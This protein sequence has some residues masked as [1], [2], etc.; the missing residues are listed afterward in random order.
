MSDTSLPTCGSSDA[1]TTDS[2]SSSSPVSSCSS[3]T[4]FNP[5]SIEEIVNWTLGTQLVNGFY[6]DDT[7]NPK[8]DGGQPIY[9]DYVFPV[10]LSYYPSNLGTEFENQTPFYYAEASA[11]GKNEYN[12]A[13]FNGGFYDTK[14]PLWVIKSSASAE[15][16]WSTKDT[17]KIKT[18]K[19]SYNV[20]TS[21]QSFPST[22]VDG[23]YQIIGSPIEDNAIG[24][25]VPTEDYADFWDSGDGENTAPSSSAPDVVSATVGQ[26]APNSVDFTIPASDSYTITNSS[27]V[28]RAFS[29]AF[30]LQYSL[31][32]QINSGLGTALENSVTEEVKAG[33]DLDFS[34]SSE[35]Y[36]KQEESIQ[37]ST[38]SSVTNNYSETIFYEWVATNTTYYA[39]FSLPGYLTAYQSNLDELATEDG[40]SESP[41]SDQVYG[42]YENKNGEKVK[43]YFNDSVY[44]LLSNTASSD[45]GFSGTYKSSISPENQMITASGAFSA[46]NVGELQPYFF[47]NN[48]DSCGSFD[49]NNIPTESD[50]SSASSRSIPI[51]KTESNGFSWKKLHAFHDRIYFNNH[52]TIGVEDENGKQDLDIGSRGKTKSGYFNIGTQRSDYYFNPSKKSQGAAILHEGNDFYYGH[53]KKDFVSS[54][55]LGGTTAIR[56]KGGKDRVLIDASASYGEITH[57]YTHLGSGADKYKVVGTDGE[58]DANDYQAEFVETGAGK[59][60][61][62][63]NGNVKLVVT[64]F[65]PFK[66]ELVIDFD[67]Y[68]M[69]GN[70]S[71]ISF[72]NDEGSTITLQGLATSID[73]SDRFDR[74]SVA[75]PIDMVE[76]HS[77]P[78]ISDIHRFAYS[79]ITGFVVFPLVF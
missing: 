22:S 56:T 55:S 77:D 36:S 46:N 30:D 2:D 67:N 68:R 37:F 41:D 59:D 49:A 66:D 14:L 73:R 33:L 17:S 10:S 62:F 25:F 76:P 8:E 27:L 52:L 58:V 38:P 60:K 75:G 71:D 57:G 4:S 78:Y 15:D 39:T 28:E 1:P 48:D 72:I 54:K 61:I 31:K 9:Y 26:I 69:T 65:D 63:V 29:A 79:Q 45:S 21:D 5:A 12:D 50:C 7:Y 40:V 44:N 20:P 16:V 43:Y 32:D 64:D 47:F 13:F 70:H 3:S 6:P 11:K 42:M 19:L 34:E 74:D 23:Y 53:K 18:G 35:K 24:F 51:G